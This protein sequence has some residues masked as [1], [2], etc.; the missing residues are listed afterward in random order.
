MKHATYALEIWNPFGRHESPTWTEL[1]P[2]RPQLDPDSL[3]T[4]RSRSS[5]QLTS[6][7]RCPFGKAAYEPKIRE[8]S[9]RFGNIKMLAPFQ[10]IRQILPGV[11]PRAEVPR[12]LS[13]PPRV[14]TGAAVEKAGALINR[15]PKSARKRKCAASHDRSEVR[16]RSR[17]ELT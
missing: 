6:Y 3:A 10:H 17:P 13:G 4:L 12:D 9:A 11:L 2:P 15:F 14:E 7:L 16:S 5:W 1:A 8:V